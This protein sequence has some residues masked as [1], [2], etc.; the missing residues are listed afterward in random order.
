MATTPRR[1]GADS[2]AVQ[3][4]GLRELQ[5]ALRRA[6]GRTASELRRVNKAAAELTARRARERASSLGGVAAKAAPSVRAAAEQRFAKV[7][8]GG[9]RHPYALGAN[10]GAYHDRPRVDRR[11]R[12]LQGWNQFPA[13]TGNQHVGGSRDRFLYWAIGRTRDEFMDLYGRLLDQLSRGPFP[14]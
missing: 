10:F 7:A 5:R 4:L 6:E 13:W 3:I 9:A 12:S 8:I 2:A 1:G 14:D 11:G